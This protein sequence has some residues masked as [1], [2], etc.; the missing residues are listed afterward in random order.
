M[1]TTL[2]RLEVGVLL[3]TRLLLLTS[4][5][6][7]TGGLYA[8]EAILQTQTRQLKSRL[9]QLT[10]V[11]WEK[12]MSSWIMLGTIVNLFETSV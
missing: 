7:C 2:L 3:L 1:P 9:L 6:R 11:S 10:R 4:A 8:L 12:L 5:S